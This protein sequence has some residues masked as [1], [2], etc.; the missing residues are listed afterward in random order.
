MKKK[1][2]IPTFWVS[3]MIPFSP[4]NTVTDHLLPILYLVSKYPILLPHVWLSHT[5]GPGTTIL[6]LSLISE[7]LPTFPPHLK[8]QE[9]YRWLLKNAHFLFYIQYSKKQVVVLLITG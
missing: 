8:L 5:Y 6:S 2:H 4:S 7:P 9:N 3:H 1:N